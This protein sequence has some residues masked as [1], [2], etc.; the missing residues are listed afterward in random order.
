MYRVGIIGLG[1]IAAF[2]GT[3]EEK[4]PYCHVGGIRFSDRV[5]LAAVCDN[6]L[7]AQ[8]KFRELWGGE[9]P[10]LNYFSSSAEMLQEELD[11][12]AVCVRGPL[13]YRV[14][15]EVLAAK[16]KAVFLEK[17]PTSSLA[18]MDELLAIA[19]SNGTNIIVS[20]SRHWSP[21][22]LRMQEL[23]NEGL[24]GDVTKVVG[25]S[26][27]TVLSFASHTTDLMCQF[28]GYCPESVYAIGKVSEAGQDG[29]EPEPCYDGMMI[30]FKNG[31]TG[32][33]VGDRGAYDQ[34]YCDVHGTKGRI[35]VGMHT[36]FAAVTNEGQPIDLD[37]Y[38][39]PESQSVFTVA[40]NQ[41]AD[42]LDGGPV[43]HCSN[44]HFKAVNEIGFAAIESMHSKQKVELA[45]MNRTRKVY[46]D[47]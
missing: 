27:G 6:S 46:A 38:G 14:M 16:P 29:Y 5:K 26:G 34:I 19:S 39:L 25:Y 32:I 28:A 33:Q 23:V 35:R 24:I 8:D 12:V 40:Y 30:E 15:K 44:D 13:H 21:R 1:H 9:F 42:Y 41:I 10:D 37:A 4:E 17:P 47:G 3:P 43:P 22:V 45:T 20:Y 11:I 7:T 36:E 2:Y 31:V 18:E